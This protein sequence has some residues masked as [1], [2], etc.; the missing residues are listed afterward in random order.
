ML[1]VLTGKFKPGRGIEVVNWLRNK[2][3]MAKLKDAFPGYVNTYI[4]ERGNVDHHFVIVNEIE[5]YAVLD[6]WNKSE[7]VINFMREF[8][9]ELGFYGTDFQ[10]SFLKSVDDVN[11]MDQDL[12]DQLMAKEKARSS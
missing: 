3:N 10:E 5:N 8:N 11:M 7:K 6:E 1:R 2:E 9:L 12:F 4:V